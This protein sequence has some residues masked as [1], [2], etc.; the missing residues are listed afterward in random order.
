MLPVM[1]TRALSFA[2]IKIRKRLTSESILLGT[3]CCALLTLCSL[4]IAVF[5]SPN[6]DT[7]YNLISVIGFWLALTLFPSIRPDMRITLSPKTIVLMCFFFKL[8]VAPLS[9]T[10]FGLSN[11]ALLTLPETR[12]LIWANIYNVFSFLAFCCGWSYVSGKALVF[13]RPMSRKVIVTLSI[14]F[15]IFGLF[16]LI[17]NYNF[18]VDYALVGNLSDNPNATVLEYLVKIAW[19]F[20]PYS[21]VLVFYE[22][23]SSKAKLWLVSSIL[24][25]VLTS[26]FIIILTINPNRASMIY[27]LVALL[28]TYSLHVK[29][30][31]Y[32]VLAVAAFVTFLAVFAFGEAK[33]MAMTSQVSQGSSHVDT[34][35]VIDS[36]HWVEDIQLYFGG[37][38]FVAFL[39]RSANDHNIESTLVSSFMEPIPILGRTFRDTSGSCIYNYLIYGSDIARDQVFPTVG[40]LY[41]NFGAIGMI[42]GYSLIGIGYKYLYMWFISAKRMNFIFTFSIFIIA[43][44][45]NALIVLSFSVFSQFIF[46]NSLPCFLVIL[47][48]IKDRHFRF[49]YL[50]ESKYRGAM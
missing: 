34:Q 48:G 11:G 16:S 21:I 15:S 27:P 36:V 14:V 4:F 6:F 45:Y 20:I 3:A 40:E 1:H 13:V 7:I 12:E 5:V 47:A 32:K 42:I 43:L 19:F 33:K 31:S 44:Y 29:R 17:G 46:Y 35:K 39:F 37:P 9:A 38:Q 50:G 22:F 26:L 30:I 28:A 18:S 41:L 23:T 8:V 49:A 10:V 24:G 25:L 2:P